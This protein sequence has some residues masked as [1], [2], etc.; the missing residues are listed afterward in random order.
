MGTPGF[1][2]HKFGHELNVLVTVFV[3]SGCEVAKAGDFDNAGALHE[4]GVHVE[5]AGPGVQQVLVAGPRLAHPADVVRAQGVKLGHRGIPEL[6]PRHRPVGI[7]EFAEEAQPGEVELN[8]LVDQVVCNALLG[9]HFRLDGGQ[10]QAPLRIDICVGPLPRIPLDL[11]NR[12]DPLE[13][14]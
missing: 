4:I 7:R 14:T 10:K 2:L 11:L 8:R 5:V 12:D 13:R 3:V 9:Q 1:C 6:G